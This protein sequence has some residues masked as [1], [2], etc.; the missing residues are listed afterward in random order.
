MDMG[1]VRVKRLLGFLLLIYLLLWGVS[2]KNQEG[3]KQNHFSSP[4]RLI[5][6]LA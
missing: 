5:S 6:F 4:A 2:A 3:Q 1:G